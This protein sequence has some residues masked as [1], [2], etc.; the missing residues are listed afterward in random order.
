MVIANPKSDWV[1][2]WMLH[3]GVAAWLCRPDGTI[4]HLNRNAENLLRV[5]AAQCL[6][7]PCFEVIQ[8]K[9]IDGRPFCSSNCQ[10]ARQARASEEIHP[11]M[12]QAPGGGDSHWLRVLV[13][14]V[15]APDKSHPW[16]VH[17][18]IDAD[19]VR[20]LERYVSHLAHRSPH[21]QG[22]PPDLSVL[23]PRE[24]E[25]LN[26]MAHDLTLQAIANRLEV[27][28]ST[29]RNHV[30]HILSKLEVHSIAEAIAWHLLG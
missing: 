13:I 19:S 11:Y 22:S 30:Q 8:G 28:H 18:A 12:I 21:E 25:V 29:V 17:C 1:P 14:V 26:L 24:R 7:R 3:L 9:A 6:N 5:S 20:R 10:I 27:Q 2:S 16:L 23:S 15:T 4:G